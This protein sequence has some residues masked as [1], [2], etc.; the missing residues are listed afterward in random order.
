MSERKCCLSVKKSKSGF[1]PGLVYGLL[2]HSFCLGFIVFSIIGATAATTVFWRLL[3]LPYFF[4]ILVVL[5]LVFATISAAFYLKRASLFSWGGIKKKWRYLLTLYGMAVG[6]NLLFFVIVFPWMA[7]VRNTPKVLSQQVS[8]SSAVLQVEI[9][10]PGHAPLI[11]EELT[12]IPGVTAVKF[13]FPNLFAIDYDQN[14]V[15]LEKILQLQIFEIY[16]A[17]VV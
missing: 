16:K 15:S 11:T 2:P 13:Q 17:R 9:P 5:S 4:Q 10:C 3:L 8:L 14:K 7:N 1:V 12:K 6:V